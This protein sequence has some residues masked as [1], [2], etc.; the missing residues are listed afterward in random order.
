MKTVLDI[1]STRVYKFCN[2]FVKDHFNINEF[3]ALIQS[4]F[5]KVKFRLKMCLKIGPEC[6]ELFD[7][8]LLCGGLKLPF[9]LTFNSIHV[10]N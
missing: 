5:F 4:F 10:L 9:L 8:S 2:M 1:I 3:T 7:H 6:S